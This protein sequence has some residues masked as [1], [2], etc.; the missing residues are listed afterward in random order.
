MSKTTDYFD[1]ETIAR[2]VSIVDMQHPKLNIGHFVGII[3]NDGKN[4]LVKT[5]NGQMLVS[6][7]AITDV[8]DYR[9]V[10]GYSD[11]MASSFVRDKK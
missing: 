2:V 7:V 4:H 11:F 9:I 8:D 5:S 6:F 10:A 3:S 1:K